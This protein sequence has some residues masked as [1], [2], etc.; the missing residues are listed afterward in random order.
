MGNPY[1]DPVVV[2]DGRIDDK[3]YVP[4]P[5]KEAT[6]QIARIHLDGRHMQDDADDLVETIV[7]AVFETDAFDL[8]EVTTSE[9]TYTM[10]LDDLLSGAMIEGIID[11]AATEA[12]RRDMREDASTASGI[13]ESDIVKAVHSVYEENQNL[14]HDDQ[15]DSKVESLEGRLQSVQSV[16]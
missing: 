6:E 7:N 5:D 3:L 13:T 8:Y 12:L 10:G 1:A 2:R 14:N 15:I 16:T 9:D 4:R 11:K